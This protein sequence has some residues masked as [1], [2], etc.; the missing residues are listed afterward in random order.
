MFQTGPPSEE[1]VVKALRGRC[2]HGANNGFT[3]VR[4]KVEVTFRFDSNIPYETDRLLLMSVA[5]Y[6]GAATLT[7]KQAGGEA[8]C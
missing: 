3:N 2:R 6:L 7:L 1:Q 5:Q 8:P 4:Y